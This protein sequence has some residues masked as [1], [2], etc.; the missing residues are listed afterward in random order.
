M[1]VAPGTYEEGQTFITGSALKKGKNEDLVV[2]IYFLIDG[3]TIT[4]YLYTTPDA[5]VYTE[6][7][8]RACGFDPAEHNW[9]LS[10]L[11]EDDKAKNPITGN[12]P[13]VVVEENTYNGKISSKV[14]WIGSGTGVER[15]EPEEAKSFTTALRQRLLASQGPATAKKPA[16][17]KGKSAGKPTP[18]LP[19][20]SGNRP[21][22][23]DD[24]N[25]WAP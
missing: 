21:G 7:K 23:T 1:S 14:G 12:R 24:P 9:D 10:P 17:T 2:E 4:A 6:K 8:L 16:A 13:R 18:T 20:S 11:N 15:M 22:E 3:E 25:T 5:W 19:P